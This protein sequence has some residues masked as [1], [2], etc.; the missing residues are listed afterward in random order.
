MTYSRMGNPTLPSALSGFTAEFGMGSGGAHSLWSSGK[1]VLPWHSRARVQVPD[2][3]TT[4]LTG[5][6]VTVQFEVVRT[7]SLTRARASSHTRPSTVPTLASRR[8]RDPRVTALV[9][10][11]QA[12]RAIST[13]Q[14]NASQRLHTRPINLVVFQGPS[15]DLT[16]RGDLILRGASRLDAFSGY[17][18]RT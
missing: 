14:L 7:L 10:Y 17:P 16:S 3:C 18:V 15:G 4:P 1:P 2:P 6:A 8:I 9:L 5:P 12:A 13:G 11:G